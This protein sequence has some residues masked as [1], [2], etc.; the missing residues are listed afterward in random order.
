M[1]G[2]DFR[3]CSLNFFRLVVLAVDHMARFFIDSLGRYFDDQETVNM[4]QSLVFLEFEVIFAI[5]VVAIIALMLIFYVI[6]PVD[7]DLKE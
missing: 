1:R 2:V 4:E 6:F 3:G 7:K 5:G